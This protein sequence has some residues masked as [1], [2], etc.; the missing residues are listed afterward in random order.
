MPTPRQPIPE[1]VASRATRQEGLIT[2]AQ[3]R[4]AGTSQ[5][6]VERLVRTGEWSRITRGVFDT[7]A[8]PVA[9]RPVDHRRKRAAWAAMLTYGPSAVAV[10]P[11]ALALLGV[12]GL[13]SR[14]VP[15]A[16]LPGGR[17]LETRDGI[18]L[19]M[20]DDGMTVV[21]YEDRYVASPAWA[22]AQAVPELER[23]YAV[24]VMDSALRRDLI[25]PATLERAHDHAR[26]RRGVAAT[27]AW[28]EL[29]DSRAE[30]PLET[31]ARLDCIDGGVPPDALQVPLTGSSGAQRR[32]DLG[33][34]L[35]DGR[36]LVGEVDGAEF[37]DAPEAVYTDRERHNDLVTADVAAVLRF[38]SKD[39]R[40]PGTTH[41]TVRR[42]LKT[43][44]RRRAA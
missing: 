26:G 16:A 31:W 32:G 22:L 1:D 15:Q 24:S 39:V 14:V 35:D 21:R 20:F 8:R 11:C 38:T 19:R 43:T 23:G 12:T 28:W 25:T 27:H 7:D 10:G 9:L 5:K 4:E 42:A 34:Q 17:A 2:T 37:H 30:S 40:S 33:W 29:A 6:V 44:G 3:C 18:R 36:W 13:P 41:R